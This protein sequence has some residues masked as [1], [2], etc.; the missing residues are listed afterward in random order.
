MAVM[1][2][3]TDSTYAS[4]RR[5]IMAGRYAP[6]TQLKEEHLAEIMGVSRTPVR[7]ALQRLVGLSPESARHRWRHIDDDA[8]A[9]CEG[10][11]RE[12][13]GCGGCG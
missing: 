10:V 2:N 6:G 13:G 3:A 9:M 7:A 11:S 5:A 1:S 4:I 8:R 12:D